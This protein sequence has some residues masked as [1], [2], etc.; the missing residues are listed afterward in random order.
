C[1]KTTN[2]SEPG[3]EPVFLE[4]EGYR[5]GLHA[6]RQV[7]H[8]KLSYVNFAGMVTETVCAEMLSRTAY[9]K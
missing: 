1:D 7:F 8:E 5:T 4:L 2:S 6:M 3:I 9:G